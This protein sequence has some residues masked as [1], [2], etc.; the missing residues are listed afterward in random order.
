LFSSVSDSQVLSNLPVLLDGLLVTLQLT[1]MA[2]LLSWAGGL[3][4]LLSQLSAF[5]TIR[6]PG[7]IYISLM[8]GTPSLLQLFLIFFSLPLVGLEGMPMLAAVLALGLNSAAYVAEILRANYRVVDPGQVEAA[9]AIGLSPLR[10][11]LRIRL[12]QMITASR[13]A[14]INEFT[15][16]LKTT[17]LASVVAVPEL[18]YSGQLITARTFEATEVLLFVAAGYFVLAAPIILL[19]R[20]LQ[21]SVQSPGGKGVS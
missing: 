13:P 16:L 11:W 7:R 15:I 20:K 1:V 9:M 8:R 5:R 18:T 12:P 3:L 17:P 6:I 21:K 14:L 4:I 19:G 10:T 2:T